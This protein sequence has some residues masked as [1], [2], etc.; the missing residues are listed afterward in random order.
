MPIGNRFKVATIR[1]IPIYVATSW[2]W[3]ALIWGFAIYTNLQPAVSS[4]VR[5]A[6]LTIFEGVLFFGGVLLHEAAHAIAARGFGLPVAGITL[7][8]WGGATETASSA[9]GPRA[10]F[11]IAF[12]G[13]ATTL[14]LAAAFWFAAGAVDIGLTRDILRELAWLNLFIGLAN[15]LP[16]FPLDGGRMLLA[17]TW[18]IT[19]NRRTAVLVAGYGAV[20]VGAALI[21]AAILTFR[22]TTGLWLFLGYLGFVMLTTGRGT[23][24]R[25]KARDILARGTAADAMRPPP[26]EQIP[27]RSPSR[28]RR[29]GGS[30]TSRIGRSR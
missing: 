30:A 22:S 27:R 17:A 21:G 14:V 28:R 24:Q 8:F 29:P 16:G 5:A 23:P 6:W 18:A 1:G 25:V 7:V 9:K 11:V 20:V 2:I 26:T 13:P 3:I 19:K 4:P 10:E 12:V 15:A